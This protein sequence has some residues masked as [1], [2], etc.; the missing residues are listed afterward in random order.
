MMTVTIAH[1]IAVLQQMV[2]DA[3]EDIELL[4]EEVQQLKQ[5]NVQSQQAFDGLNLRLGRCL[6]EFYARVAALEKN[7]DRIWSEYTPRE[8]TYQLAAL[9]CEM[10]CTVWPNADDRPPEL[11]ELVRVRDGFERH[12]AGYVH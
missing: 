7:E 4:S 2:K 9:A 3:Q 1:A 10:A 5:R 8:L 6:Q 12:G 11:D